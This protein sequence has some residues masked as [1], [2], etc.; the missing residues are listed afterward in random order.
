MLSPRSAKSELYRYTIN[1][2]YHKCVTMNR[3]HTPPSR[4]NKN[5]PDP[6]RSKTLI[7][8][9]PF[10]FKFCHLFIFFFLTPTAEFCSGRLLTNTT[11]LRLANVWM[12]MP[13]PLLKLKR[14]TW[15]APGG[16]RRGTWTRAACPTAGA[17][18]RAA[19]AGR[20]DR[21]ADHHR[22]T[23]HVHETK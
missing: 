2:Q 14:G 20:P 9:H 15:D 11:T 22:E 5:G 12:W 4:F 3:I 18:R 7:W 21:R 16:R 8:K 6:T 10:I 1:C 17:G 19:P 23:E 13:E